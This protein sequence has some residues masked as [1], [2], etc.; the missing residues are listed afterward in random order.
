MA[1]IFLFFT[2]KSPATCPDPFTIFNTPAGRPISEQISANF[3]AVKGVISDGLART[4]FPTIKAGA[5]FHV[6]R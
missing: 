3:E 2:N 4:V 6:K 1:F 5:I